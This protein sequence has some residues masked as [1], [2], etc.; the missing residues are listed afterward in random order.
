MRGE[1]NFDGCSV[2]FLVKCQVDSPPRPS[3]DCGS[4]LV[5]DP[6]RNRYADRVSPALLTRW[7]VGKRF[8]MGRR[9][10]PLSA[11]PP[12]PAGG[13]TSPAQLMRECRD[14]IVRQSPTVG[15]TPSPTSK[16]ATDTEGSVAKCIGRGRPSDQ[17]P[18]RCPV[19]GVGQSSQRGPTYEGARPVEFTARLHIESC[20]LTKLP[21]GRNGQKPGRKT[22]RDGSCLVMPGWETTV[23][24]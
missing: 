24:G 13:R 7:S 4:V 3:P 1:I 19:V 12:T 18:P 10:Y 11:G 17:S 6:Q 15:N 9:L 23:M 21:R 14:G 20:P 8:L 22:T 2:G 16:A 5:R